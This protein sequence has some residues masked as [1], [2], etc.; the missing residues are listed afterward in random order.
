MLAGW[1]ISQGEIPTYPSTSTPE[2]DISK[3]FARGI[4]FQRM[5]L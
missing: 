4:N 1:K 2:K 3:Y 5:R